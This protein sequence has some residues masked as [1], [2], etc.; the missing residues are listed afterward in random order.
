MVCTASADSGHSSVPMAACAPLRSLICR[1]DPAL[2]SSFAQPSTPIS[3]F[4][5]RLQM[6]R[7]VV[8]SE[9]SELWI[10]HWMELSSMS[11]STTASRGCSQTQCR[12]LDEAANV[13]ESTKCSPRETC[14]S[15]SENPDMQ[16]GCETICFRF[17]RTL[18]HLILRSQAAP[19]SL[20][21]KKNG[22][23][24]VGIGSPKAFFL[25]YSSTAL[26]TTFTVFPIQTVRSLLFTMGTDIR[27]SPINIS[28]ISRT[29]KA[30]RALFVSWRCLHPALGNTSIDQSSLG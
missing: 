16:N 4:L 20:S 11:S 15:T 23:K 9:L 8:W 19:I 29:V 28:A 24:H 3:C 26:R 10:G 7:R 30:L 21:F 13:L 25:T 12:Q 1:V 5:V 18:A 17:I 27:V 6:V 14:L 2:K 22:K